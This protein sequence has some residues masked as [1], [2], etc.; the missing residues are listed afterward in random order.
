MLI[1]LAWQYFEQSKKT[2]RKVPEQPATT[3]SRESRSN[4]SAV[5]VPGQFDFYL[6][7]L[8]VE[9]AWCEDGNAKRNQCRAIDRRLHE[10]RPLVL[11]GLWPEYH[12]AGKYPE[13]CAAPALK[14]SNQLHKQLEYWMPGVDE[15]LDRHEW[16]RH[17]SCTGLADDTYFADSVSLA[18]RV[19][20][21][22]NGALQQYSGQKLTPAT[23]RAAAAK[24][25]PAI[26]DSL[27]FV[28]KNLR[29]AR[30]AERGRPTLLE[31]RLCIDNDGAAGRPQSLLQCAAVNR[32]DQGCG[33]EFWIDEF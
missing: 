8:T 2:P 26:A 31:V 6:L 17:G 18:Q 9:S 14:L 3:T 28:C 23:L 7:S 11:H 12:P 13:N 1:A 32:R 24:V 27:V 15:G 10:Q 29:N 33:R 30:P 4:K 5:H 20:N 19:A 25:E 16:R 21:T 22:L